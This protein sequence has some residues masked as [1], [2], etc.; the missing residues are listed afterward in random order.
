VAIAAILVC[1][2]LLRLYEL[3]LKPLHHDEGVNGFLLIRLV[4]DG[5]YRYDPANYHGST[6]YYFALVPTLFRFNTLAIRTVPVLFGLVTI[7]LILYLRRYLGTIGVLTAAALAAVS[8]CAVYYSRYFIH[9]TL[10]VCFTVGTVVAALL[11]HETKRPS[12]LM[13]VS[14]VAALM[15]ATKETATIAAVV[16]LAAAIGARIYIRFRG[17][18]SR[19][20]VK[21]G[22][23]Q[24]DRK[25]LA[26]P[27]LW[28]L[29]A[30]ALFIVIN[31]AFYSSFLT[32][33]GGVKGALETFAIW[34]STSEI[35][36]TKP[37]H[38]YF[39]WLFRQDSPSLL[40][41]MS[42]AGLA[43]WRGESPFAIF[44]ALWSLGILSVYSL[45]PYKTPWLT[46]N[47]IV[48]LA[49]MGGYM[50]NVVYTRGK[51]MLAV[52]LVCM[53]MGISAYQAI[54]L[55]FFHYDDENFAY[56]YMHTRREFL[57][58]VNTINQLAE[59][60]G[61]GAGTRIAVLAPEYWPLPWYLRD[62]RNAGFYGKAVT[63]PDAAIVVAAQAQEMAV[64]S[65][66]GQ[67][68]QR[69]DVYPLRPAVSLVLYARRGLAGRLAPSTPDRVKP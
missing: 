19:E 43:L 20:S 27:A 25:G 31:V 14:A 24:T 58:L 6:L 40:L 26:R 2:A 33:E 37:W 41:G 59:G 29:S 10:L 62:Y 48:P 28:V 52:A 7:W 4:R 46:L 49:I 3:E 38:T 34:R 1:A 44:A 57:Q 12:D 8:P 65:S 13:R 5:F 56:P 15:F 54:S 51:R 61:T 50:V 32:Y 11:Y 47:M 55:N 66:L 60:A 30:A 67:D 69:I 63:I 36:H 35:A 9:E 16:L 64:Q 45:V 42:G 22:R 17:R 18:V 21:D 39:E 23:H 53:A 68:Y